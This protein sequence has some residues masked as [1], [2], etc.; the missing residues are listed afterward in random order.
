MLSLG[1]NF[2]LILAESIKFDRLPPDAIIVA[3][4]SGGE[5]LTVMMVEALPENIKCCGSED[6]FSAIGFAGGFFPA[7]PQ[8]ALL[9]FCQERSRLAA[10]YRSIGSRWMDLQANHS[11]SKSWPACRG[12]YHPP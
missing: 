6:C 11:S 12:L 2:C 5:L 8:C 10:P 4:Q 7:R 9:L 3:D 1:L